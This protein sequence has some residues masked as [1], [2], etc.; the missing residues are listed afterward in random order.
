MTKTVL[1]EP[2]CKWSAEAFMHYWK[3]PDAPRATP[4]TA[5]IVGHR[6]RPIGVVRGADDYTRVIAAMLE[7]C[8]EFPIDR[9]RIRRDRRFYVPALDCDGNRA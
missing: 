6:P 3:A 7:I 5:D 1:A 9:P 2:N 4:V 8:P